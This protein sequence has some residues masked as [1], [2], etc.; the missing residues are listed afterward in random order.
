MFSKLRLRWERSP[1]TAAGQSCSHNGRTAE[2]WID[3]KSWNLCIQSLTRIQPDER[4]DAAVQW[5]TKDCPFIEQAIRKAEEILAAE[6]QLG[7]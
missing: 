6:W 7:F 5:S 3:G 1:D 2:L 4:W